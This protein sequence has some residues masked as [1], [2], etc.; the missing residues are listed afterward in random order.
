[1]KIAVQN[2]EFLKRHGACVVLPQVDAYDYLYGINRAGTYLKPPDVT[3]TYG[4]CYSS[5]KHDGSDMIETNSRHNRDGCTFNSGNARQWKWL[6]NFNHM[7]FLHESLSGQDPDACHIMIAPK[8]Q[9]DQIRPANTSFPHLIAQLHIPFTSQGKP[10]FNLRMGKGCKEDIGRI[11]CFCSGPMSRNLESHFKRT[12]FGE[13]QLDICSVIMSTIL[14]GGTVIS[15]ASGECRLFDLLKDNETFKRMIQHARRDLC[16]SDEWDARKPMKRKC[17]D[18]IWAKKVIHPQFNRNQ[19]MG[20]FDF[21]Q[22]PR[23]T[24]ACT[25]SGRLNL[26]S[27]ALWVQCNQVQY[28]PNKKFGEYD[29]EEQKQFHMKRRR[30]GK[31]EHKTGTAPQQYH[32]MFPDGYRPC[33]HVQS[34]RIGG[35]PTCTLI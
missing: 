19:Y 13:I 33:D 6:P 4:M 30:F 20:Y 17:L 32:N 29:E 21:C 2:R 14:K 7:H 28:R 23:E 5:F 16:E 31:N 27:V 9:I 8:G 3:I 35:I 11:M 26:D 34:S 24:F 12:E 15:L 25:S 1:M 18:G 10:I 22:A